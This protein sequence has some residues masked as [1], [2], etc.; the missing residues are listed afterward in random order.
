MAE[1][2]IAL[3]RTLGTLARPRIW[4][5]LAGPAVAAAAHPSTVTVR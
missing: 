4:L 3:V 5:L 1:L 2:M